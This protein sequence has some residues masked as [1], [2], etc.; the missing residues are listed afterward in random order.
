MLFQTEQFVFLTS[1]CQSST[2]SFSHSYS[3]YKLPHARFL[4]Q[5][6]GRA[7]GIKSPYIKVCFCKLA[8][9]QQ[10]RSRGATD[11]LLKCG[12]T[13]MF[14]WRVFGWFLLGSACERR[15]INCKTSGKEINNNNNNPTRFGLCGLLR[16]IPK[17]QGS[18]NACETLNNGVFFSLARTQNLCARSTKSVSCKRVY[19]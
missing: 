14:R 11:S 18:F 1:H 16:L 2:R 9:Q 17:D 13:R 4:R 12:S 6:P 5:T 8:M 15:D 7:F 19:H 10:M 3:K